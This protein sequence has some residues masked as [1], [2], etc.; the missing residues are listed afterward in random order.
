MPSPASA[1]P[2]QITNRG[3]TITL[4]ATAQEL[5]AANSHRSGFSLQNL[6]AGDLY[7]SEFGDASAG[8]PST[9]VIPGAL[10]E[11]PAGIAPTG[12]VSVYGATTA[13]AFSAREW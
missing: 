11:T 9:K 1:N 5:M 12:A 3:G 6:S 10:Y 8:Q 7:F 4:G 2:G 13:Q